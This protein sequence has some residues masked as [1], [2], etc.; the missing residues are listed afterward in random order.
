MTVTTANK[1]YGNKAVESVKAEIRQLLVKKVWHPVD[2]QFV[3]RYRNKI[4]RSFVFVK[5]KYTSQGQVD[6]L[7]SRL[8]AGG[9]MQDRTLHYNLSNKTENISSVFMIVAIAAKER[10]K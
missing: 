8:V 3:A 1:N 9:H 7:K 6:K 2:K 5:L 4:V 10:R